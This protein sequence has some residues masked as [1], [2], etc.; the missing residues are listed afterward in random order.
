MACFGG[1]ISL[2]C[3]VLL[4]DETEYPLEIRVSTAYKWTVVTVVKCVEIVWWTRLYWSVYGNASFQVI[5]RFISKG[6]KPPWFFSIQSGALKLSISCCGMMQNS[7]FFNSHVI[8]R[9][10][11]SS[12][13]CL[14]L[15]FRSALL[16]DEGLTSSIRST[17]PSFAEI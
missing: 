4:L 8:L 16:R 1:D 12:I 9:I 10:H 3:H 5:L 2:F 14:S 11:F 13:E 15:L 7:T 17:A 6:G